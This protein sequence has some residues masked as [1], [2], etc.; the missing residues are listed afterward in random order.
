MASPR[1]LMDNS[2]ITLPIQDIQFSHAFSSSDWHKPSY[3]SWKFNSLDESKDYTFITDYFVRRTAEFLP[4][5]SYLWLLESPGIM[6]D[7]YAYARAN[8]HLYSKIFTHNRAIIEENPEKAIL[9][10]IGGCHLSD[11]E[12]NCEYPKTKLVSMIFSPQSWLPGHSLRH[13][14]YHKFGNRIDCMGS[15]ITGIKQRKIDAGKDYKFQVVIENVAED[16]YFTEKL[17]DALLCGCIP[18]YWGC[19][20]IGNF[21]NTSGFLIFNNIEEFEKILE[22]DLD[23]FWEANQAV[24]RENFDNALK[25]KIAEDF[26]W[27][28]YKYLLI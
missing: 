15:G 4:K 9:L 27:K 25:Y 23:S 11:D 14:I 13:Q 18:I 5:K 3:F 22:S 17:I 6:A 12:I 19:P 1:Y 10:P 26:L 8:S 24:I 2:I 16:Y 28:N 21:F 7:A 20:S